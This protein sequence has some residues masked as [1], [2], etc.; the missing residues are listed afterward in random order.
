[1]PLPCLTTA[2]ICE[3]VLIEQDSVLSVVRI[4]DRIEVAETPEGQQPRFT[5]YVLVAVKAGVALGRHSLQLVSRLPSGGQI[6]KPLDFEPFEL[7]T[8]DEGANFVV[9][10]GLEITEYGT[11]G[12][13]VLDRAPGSSIATKDGRPESCR[14]SSRSC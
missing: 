2:L 13:D 4:L 8:E 9:R 1:M 14:S 12:I 11:Y 6:K 3:K 7:K 10:T 5:F